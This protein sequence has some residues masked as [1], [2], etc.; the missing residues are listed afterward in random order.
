[1][2]E[3]GK[4]NRGCNKHHRSPTAR[5]HFLFLLFRYPVSAA[6]NRYQYPFPRTVI[7]LQ[8]ANE[9]H[10]YL[11]PF[12]SITNLD[13]FPGGN[14]FRERMRFYLFS[15]WIYLSVWYSSIIRPRSFKSRIETNRRKFGGEFRGKSWARDSTI[16]NGITLI[17]NLISVYFF[18]RSTLASF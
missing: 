13:P 4:L 11:S 3:S 15:F 9:I 8:L 1:M 12:W 18:S 16:E 14:S 6:N 10:R 2:D 5:F 17:D 7:A